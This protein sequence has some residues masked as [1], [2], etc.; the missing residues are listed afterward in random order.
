MS[1][2]AMSSF[3][4]IVRGGLLAGMLALAASC[5]TAKLEAPT[6]DVTNAPAAGFSYFLIGPAQF[7]AGSYFGKQTK[8]L[9]E[10]DGRSA[11]APA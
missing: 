7:I 5:T 3:I 10:H 11:H 4:A 6:P 2:T 1:A 8:A 9:A